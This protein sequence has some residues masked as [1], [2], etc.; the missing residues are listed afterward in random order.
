MSRHAARE[1]A[2]QTL[3]QLDVNRVDEDEAVGHTLDIVGRDAHDGTYFRSL[4]RGI[5]EKQ[6]NV[7]GVIEE[8][9]EGWKVDR[10]PGVDRNILRIGVYELLY[11]DDLPA[12]VILNEAVELGKMYGT[13]RS[14]KFINGV[15]AGVLRNLPALRGTM[16]P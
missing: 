3:F 1:R 14:A 8:Y 10:M 11:E 16:R 5:L 13:E 6:K 2:L 4:L 15:L 7:D 9:S 12:P